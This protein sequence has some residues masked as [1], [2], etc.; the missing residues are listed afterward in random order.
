VLLGLGWDSQFY[1]PQK[2]GGD[3]FVVG[4]IDRSIWHIGQAYFQI[5]FR[6]SQ[7]TGG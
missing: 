4:P 7:K 6:F 3:F 2:L 5:H 1:I